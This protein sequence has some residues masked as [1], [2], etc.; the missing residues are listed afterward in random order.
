[1][2]QSGQLLLFLPLNDRSRQSEVSDKDGDDGAE[3][4]DEH[5]DD[6]DS[7]GDD[8]LDEDRLRSTG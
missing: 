3:Q 7:A 4:D 5:D 2:P 8:D 6:G 1:M